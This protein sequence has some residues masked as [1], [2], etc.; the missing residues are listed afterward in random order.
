MTK[1][2]AQGRH[3]AVQFPEIEPAPDLLEVIATVPH[4]PGVYRMLS[5]SQDVLYV[6]KARDLKKRVSSYF[7]KTAGLDPRIQS[8][9]SQVRAVEITVT[10]SESEALLLENNLIKTFA[11]RY[12]ILY[13]DDKSYPYLQITGH[14]YPKL[15]FY[16]GPLD[17]PHRYFGPFSSAS[18][19]RDSIQ[20]MQKV[21]RLRT[22][23]DTVFGN[24]SR[25]CLLHQIRRCSAPCVGLIDAGGYAE[26]VRNAELFLLGRDDEVLEKLDKQMQL[27]A[28][29]LA[30]EAAAAYRDQI[31]ALRGVRQTQFVSS[32]RAR[33]VDIVALVSESGLLCVNLVTIRGGM[34]RGDKSFFPEHAEG[35]DEAVALEAFLGQHYPNREVP[36]LILVNR[37]MDTE[38]MARLL[39][40]QAGHPV[41]ISSSSS[42]ERRKWLDM[43]QTNAR[44]SMQQRLHLQATQEARLSSLQ[45][46]LGLPASTQR[47][48]CFDISHTMGEATV[49]S[50]VVWDE[51]GMKNG[52]YRHYNIQGVAPGDDYGAMR[53]VLDR[54][55]RRVVSGEGRVPDL[56]LID[57]GKGQVSSAVSVLEE[58]GLGQVAIVGVAKGVE[59]K[60]GLEQLILP[61]RE[62]PVRL[63]RDHAGLHLIQ[64]I[65][66]EAHRFAITGH[67]GR[68]GKARRTSTLENID[69]VGAKRRQKLLARFGG[70]RGLAS[71]SVEDLAQVEGISRVLAERIYR[72]LH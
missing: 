71:A 16:R 14:A 54:R 69:G 52:D 34:H 46:A 68:R 5:A 41:Q 58:L 53:E 65:R 19:V 3:A 15:G 36:P 45:E 64:Q 56:I 49:A 31:R 72:Y 7:Q 29:D 21:F 39:S 10:R 40:E 57:G 60:P 26:D 61:G 27:A 11:P 22:C 12:N 50:C 28:Q 24:R 8:M 37:G 18:A 43:A 47:I 48:E 51:G 42:G 59:R 55:Y 63:P 70:L 66:D 62:E 17:K 13:R 25:P 6:G 9:V 44:V 30:F 1:V 32:E 33:D 38:A 4:L 20:L 2:P 35:Y 23:E 67:R